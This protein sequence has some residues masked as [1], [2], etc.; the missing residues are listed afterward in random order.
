MVVDLCVKGVRV[1]TKRGLVTCGIAIDGGR[2]HAVAKEANL[3][4][5]SSYV[6]GNGNVALPGLIDVHVHCRD[7]GLSHKEDFLTATRSAAAGGFTTILDMPNNDP[8]TNSASRVRD[9]A[10]TAKLKTIVNVGLYGGFPKSEAEARKMCVE[11]I[12][13]FKI[14][15]ANPIADIDFG[16]DAQLKKAL[17]WAKACKRAVAIHC[18]DRGLNEAVRSE[19]KKSGRTDLYAYLMAHSP[20]SE[21]RTVKRVVTLARDLKSRLH[22]CHISLGDSITQVVK[23]RG[24]GLKVTCEVTPHHLLLTNKK[25]IKIGSTALTDPPVRDETDR[26]QSLVALAQGSIDVIASDHAPHTAKE[27]SRSDVWDVPP[28]FPGLETELPLLLTQVNKGL[29][30]L[31]RIVDALTETPSSIFGLV[32]KGKLEKGYDAD[33]TIIDPKKRFKIDASTFQSKAKYSPFDGVKVIGKP[34]MTL[35]GGRVVMDEGEI[36]AK[37]GSGTV[38]RAKRS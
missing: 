34:V 26:A 4:K 37:A 36:L 24:E 1:L 3:P 13:G 27:K 38:I 14:N 30:S 22:V 19:L 11:G 20:E 28:G 21:L 23:A 18:E 7:Q 5:A 15:L 9:R 32:R 35:V 6:D 10:D 2:I 25:L 17:R 31:G 8:P 29:L 16:D 33:V 12:V